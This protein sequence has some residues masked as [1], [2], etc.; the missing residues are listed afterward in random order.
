MQI[1]TVTEAEL[2]AYMASLPIDDE[3]L[4][5]AERAEIAEGKAAIARGDVV[6]AAEIARIVDV[7]AEPELLAVKN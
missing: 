6:G 4:T 1:S 5:E 7:S 2:K 3:E